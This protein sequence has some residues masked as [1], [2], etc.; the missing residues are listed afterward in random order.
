MTLVLTEP[1]LTL[2]KFPSCAMF[3]VE[4]NET[5]QKLQRMGN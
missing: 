5:G 3:S 2:Y 4:N 1:V